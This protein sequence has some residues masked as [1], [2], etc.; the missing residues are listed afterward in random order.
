[1]EKI[2]I[3]VTIITLNEQKNIERAIRSVSWAA[4]V[5]VVDSG[6]TDNTCAMARQLG[7]RVEN[8]SWPGYGQQKNY[9]QSLAQYPWVLNIDAD[10]QITESLKEEILQFLNR[11]QTHYL[12]AAI[13]RLTFYMNQGIRHGGWYP[14][15]LTRLCHKDFGRWTEPEVHEALKIDGT[16]TRFKHPI[17]HYAFPR[18]QDQVETN[19]LFS[20]LAAIEMNQKGIKP[21]ILKLIFKPIGKFIETFIFKRGF[22]DGLAGFI[23]SINAA[24]SMFLKYA[25]LYE[26]FEIS[27]KDLPQNKV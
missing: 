14:N 3:T 4:E 8:H 26:L 7:A 9:A 18:I 23:I 2:P 13:P 12:G 15:Y 19:I 10:E 11:E 24:H 27:K 6:S 25:N 17:L 21:S 5:I 20:K 16:V 22:L 1:M